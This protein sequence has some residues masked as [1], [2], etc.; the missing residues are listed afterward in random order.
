MFDAPLYPSL[1]LSSLM[2]MAIE[3]RPLFLNLLVSSYAHGAFLKE[4][5]AYIETVQVSDTCGTTVLAWDVCS[6]PHSL[7]L[8]HSCEIKNS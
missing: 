4:E 8:P 5:T 3:S 7:S 6:L 1:F 2:H